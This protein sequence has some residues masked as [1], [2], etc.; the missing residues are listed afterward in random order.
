MHFPGEIYIDLPP[1]ILACIYAEKIP[2]TRNYWE[3]SLC[4]CKQLTFSPLSFVKLDDFIW[5]LQVH[6]LYDYSDYY[7]R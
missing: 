3:M 2:V 5:N 1:L 7:Q 4:G 6:T